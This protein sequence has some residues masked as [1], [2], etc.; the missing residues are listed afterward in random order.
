[1]PSKTLIQNITPP[2]LEGD[3]SVMKDLP[4]WVIAKDWPKVMSFMQVSPNEPEP[5]R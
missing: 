5:E 3:T 1:M 2:L 4:D